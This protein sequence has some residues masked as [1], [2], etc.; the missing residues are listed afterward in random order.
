MKRFFLIFLSL[1]LVTGLIACKE[2]IVAPEPEP[3]KE[4]P[5]AEFYDTKTVRGVYY[6]LDENGGAVV[7]GVAEI[8]QKE[9]TLSIANEPARGYRLTGIREGAF[10]DCPNLFRLYFTG[11]AEEWNGVSVPADLPSVYCYAK[12]QPPEEGNFWYY[13]ENDSPI[14]WHY[15]H[16]DLKLQ[17]DRFLALPAACGESARYYYS[18]T[19]GEHSDTTCLGEAEP[20]RFGI[21]I[22]DAGK[23]ETVYCTREGCG[24][25]ENLNY[26]LPMPEKLFGCFNCSM[27]DDDNDYSMI[28]SSKIFYYPDCTKADY[29]TY[30]EEMK[31]LGCKVT[32]TYEMG[33]N[34]YTLLSHEKFS[35]YVS[36]LNDEKALR[37][38]V[39]RS[40]DPNPSK[41]PVADAGIC[42]PALWQININCEAAKSNGGMGYVMQ[43]TD[44]KF[45]VI[46]GGYRT[47][48]DADAI[49]E[50]LMA[51]KPKTHEKPIIAG[52]F[53]THMHIDH[54]G[55]FSTF[56]DLY[57][58]SVVVEGFYHNFLYTNV[59]DMWPNNS[60]NWENKMRTW[61]GAV[62]YRKLRSGMQFSFSG[63]TVTIICTYEDNYPWENRKED[64]P[65]DVPGT[66]FK[67]GNDT[68][69]VFKVEAGGQS[70]LFLGDAEYGESDRMMHLDDEVVHADI[71]Q[72]AHHGYDHQCRNEFYAKVN[73]TVILWPMTFV[74]WESDSHGTVF[75][76]RYLDRKENAWARSA[77]GVKKI[78][79][80]AEGT[81][82][83][84]LP[85]TPTGPRNADYDKLY[86]EQKPKN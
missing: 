22:S 64:A 28:D 18:C 4:D 48:E 53:S 82:K 47:K 2:G 67:S 72:Y 77:E 1:L 19:C 5:A 66:H 59:G 73:P 54:V 8:A 24:F 42:K 21:V 32:E 81:T 46:D 71:L 33:H 29:N 62:L 7:F 20:H 36:Y 13:G 11:S 25:M 15:H 65:L 63:A 26:E 43:L 69:L 31:N 58:N 55:A 57:Q 6:G 3:A 30:V 52:W 68:S 60:R 41:A 9:S 44:G 86:N 10:D 85:Y 34:R 70:I 79:V 12:T 50:I 45:L 56:T 84:E 37:V 83:L 17:N 23:L 51:N 78:I 74:N 80:M 14:V 61:P 49:Y 38:Y 35:A 40:D 76:W 75:L 39:G 16:F 27:G